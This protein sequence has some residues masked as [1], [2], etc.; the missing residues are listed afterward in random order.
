MKLSIERD[1]LKN[2]KFRKIVK[3]IPD[4]F[5]LT[6]MSLKPKEEIGMEIHPTTVQF[7]RIE[8]G[9]GKAILRPK[10]STRATIHYFKE[11]DA[12]IIPNNTYHNVINTSKT[13]HLKLYSIYSR[14]AH[15]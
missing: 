13:K 6:Y 12:V 2:K 8:S 11:G 14:P 10:N 5:E 1:T 9:K 3:Y 15:K 4:L 7:I